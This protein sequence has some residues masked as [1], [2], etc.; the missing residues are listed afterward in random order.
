MELRKIVNNSLSS[1]D[2]LNKY[3]ITPWE[4]LEEYETFIMYWTE[5]SPNGRKERW[6]KEKVFDP[7]RRFHYWLRNN[8]KWNKKQEKNILDIPEEIIL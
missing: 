6:E 5:K 2:I 1:K 8:K 7:S 4:L 3:N